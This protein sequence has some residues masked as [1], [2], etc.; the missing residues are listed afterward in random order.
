L[1]IRNGV[2]YTSYRLQSQDW[3]AT[4]D[5]N[6][7]LCTSTLVNGWYVF[8]V[9]GYLTSSSWTQFRLAFERGDDGDR[10]ADYIKV[11]SGDASNPSNRPVLEVEYN[12]P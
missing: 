12:V 9:T 6:G 11:Y 7:V 5:Y 2:F 4:A 8:D 10:T 1:D 3:Q